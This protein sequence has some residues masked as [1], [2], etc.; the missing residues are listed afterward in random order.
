ML[1]L[2]IVDPTRRTS[3]PTVRDRGR[4]DWRMVA[5][6]A[7]GVALFSAAFWAGMAWAI[8]AVARMVR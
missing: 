6:G 1:E 7:V 3:D 4:T 5:A 8:G 2:L